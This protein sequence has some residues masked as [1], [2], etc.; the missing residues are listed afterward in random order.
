MNIGC[1]EHDMRSGE[2]NGKLHGG[3]EE[4]ECGAN[5]VVTLQT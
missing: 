4:D 5:N 2:Y 1:F 3:M